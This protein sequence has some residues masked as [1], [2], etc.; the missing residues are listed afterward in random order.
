MH[1][2]PCRPSL[3]TFLT[4]ALAVLAPAPA[5]RAQEASPGGSSKPRT[6]FPDAQ[7]ELSQIR[8]PPGFKGEVFPAEPRVQNPS[9]IHIDEK[10]RF[11]VV[12]A[13][14][15]KNGTLDMRNL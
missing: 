13:N 1:R 15:R 3:V 14:R 6:G 8:V 11:Y 5:L 2:P 4:A 7:T 12:E 10:G 9:A